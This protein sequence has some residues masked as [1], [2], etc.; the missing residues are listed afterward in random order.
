MS[1]CPYGLSMA[2]K[3]TDQDRLLV[4]AARLYYEQGL[5]Q[6]QIS[7]RLRLSRQKVQRLLQTARNQ[8]IVQI[9]IRPI[10]GI[11]PELE[12]SLEQRFGLQEAV[13]VET[14]TY[15]DQ[16]TVA[17]EVGAGAAEY[18]LRVMQPGDSVVISWGGTLRGMVNSLSASALR[19]QFDGLKVI[20]G[21]GGLG[22]PNNETH[23]ADLTR[24]LARI[25]DGQGI[26]MPA[27]GIAGNR[28]AREAFY[29]DP[30][31]IQA[32]EQAAQADFAIMGIGAPRSDSILIQEGNIV[33]WPELAALADLG[34]VG[35]INL[36]YFDSLGQHVASD[37]DDRVI[38]LTLND[39]KQIKHVVGIAGGSAKLKAIEATLEGKLVDVLVTDHIMAQ[40]LLESN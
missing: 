1:I 36:R 34:A 16:E 12:T 14:T 9:S 17:R 26:L 23:A 2:I 28:S 19:N 37:L 4:K 33:T 30:Y 27:P 40:N 15:E 20:Q 5:T 29:S 10:M 13:I 32:L 39:I 35:D 3:I 18:I 6:V 7:K 25:L 24:R 11:I 38:G 8:G 21:L 31:V 22:N